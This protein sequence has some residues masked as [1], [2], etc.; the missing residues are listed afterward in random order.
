[1][2]NPITLKVEASMA[3]E[4]ITCLAL[5]GLSPKGTKDILVAGCHSGNMLV[6][7]V[8]TR[9]QKEQ[10]ASAHYNLIRVIVSLEAMKNR[11][12]ITADVC[13]V[14]KV[15]SSSFKPA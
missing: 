9:T 13:G 5:T 14:V 6:I 2:Q 8:S 7:S 10:M 4:T 11:F 3:T 12:F 15:W 1:M